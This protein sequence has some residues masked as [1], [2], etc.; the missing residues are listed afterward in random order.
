MKKYIF[1]FAILLASCDAPV[2]EPKGSGFW[3]GG[4]GDEKFIN[5]GQM[6]ILTHFK[7]WL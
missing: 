2:D 3:A 7:E 6:I 1:L 5:A 4:E